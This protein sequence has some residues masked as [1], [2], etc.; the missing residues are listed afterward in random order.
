MYI[1]TH[2]HVTKL[3]DKTGL[4]HLHHQMFTYSSCPITFGSELLIGKKK[5]LPSI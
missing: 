4:F 3:T 1:C 2:A 5:R